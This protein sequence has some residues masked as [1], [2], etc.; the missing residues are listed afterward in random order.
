[1]TDHD[2]HGWPGVSSDTRKVK[3]S[4][5]VAAI[6]ATIRSNRL[7]YTPRTAVVV[8][9]AIA[10]VASCIAI[11]MYVFTLRVP[12]TE[13]DKAASIVRTMS[14]HAD[15][16][17]EFDRLR[18]NQN[19][20]A[21]DEKQVT[22]TKV[23]AEK[24]ANLLLQL[25]DSPVVKKDTKVAAVYNAN[26]Q[27]IDDY[28][29]SSILLLD[30]LHTY[31]EVTKR[32]SDLSKR[33]DEPTTVAQ[34]D[35]LATGCKEYAT[36]HNAVAI[37]SYNAEVYIKY[38]KAALDFVSA[39]RKYYVASNSKTGSR[40]SLQRTMTTMDKA[41]VAMQKAGSGG[42]QYLVNTQNSG[43]QLSMLLEVINERKEITLR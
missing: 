15:K 31:G 19:N 16:M 8:L 36:K 26:R 11:S 12:D 37:K 4:K 25:Q 42:E 18:N 32:C 24:Y 6:A 17:A 3:V 33:I 22:D 40:S 14:S 30:T 9:V 28:G 1:M 7:Q 13:Y 34:F 38:R 41:Q 21:I 43:D 35:A 10:A 23:V 29:N 20:G 2:K 5:K 39:A 27:R